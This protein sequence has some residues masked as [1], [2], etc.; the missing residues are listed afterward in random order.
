M[1]N[2]QYV[3]IKNDLH[4]NHL[5]KKFP[6]FSEFSFGKSRNFE[7]HVSIVLAPDTHEPAALTLPILVETPFTYPRTKFI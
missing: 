6:I 4:Y 3:R 1:Y 2:V 7:I 5:K